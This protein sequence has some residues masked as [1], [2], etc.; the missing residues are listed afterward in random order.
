MVKEEDGQVITAAIGDGSN[1]VSMI[2]EAHIGIGIH[3]HEGLRAVQASDFAIAEF[4]YLWRLLFIHGRKA[5]I[6][7]SEMVLYFLYK[8]LVITLPHYYHA[9]NT[10]FSG[11]S[12]YED[13]SISFYN[14]IFTNFPCGWRALFDFDVS[15]E[16]DGDAVKPYI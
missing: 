2:N 12:V 16:W 8:N 14:L 6:N 15:P 13:W 3:G 10:G 11:T 1:D 7:N 9:F 5:Y 4:K